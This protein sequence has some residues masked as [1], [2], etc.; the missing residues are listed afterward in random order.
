MKKPI[1]VVMAAG[2]GSRYGGLKQLDPVG[3][4]GELII[5]YSIYDARRAG[6]ESVVFII[7]HE[8][9]DAFKQAIGD[10]LSQVIDVRYAFQQIS[11]LPEGYTIPDERTKPW[12][13]AHAVRAA[14]HAIDAPFVVI[15]ADDYYGPEAFEAIYKYLSTPQ[16]DVQCHHYAMVGYLLKNTVTEHGHVARGVC[17]VDKEGTLSEVREY[18]RIE[19]Q[20]DAIVH[21]EDEGATWQTISGETVVSMNLWGFQENFLQEIGQQFPA[22][23]DHAL[24]ENPAKAEFFLPSVVSTLIEA[25]K[26]EVKVLA[27]NEKWYGVTYQEDKPVVV[28]AIATK[29]EQALYPANLWG[30]TV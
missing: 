5:D 27:C 12:G 25:G 7:K 9:E 16:D 10:R 14:R 28:G 22:F 30:T 11:D 6:F 26:A 4:T 19:K 15:N 13:T 24:V 21:T 1:L 20:G 2:M 23:L 18:L 8:I 29:I 17:Q 3:P